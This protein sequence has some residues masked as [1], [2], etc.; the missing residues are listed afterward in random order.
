MV[1]RPLRRDEQLRYIPAPPLLRLRR[2]ELR[3]RVRRMHELIASLT[4]LAPLGQDAVRGALRAE[5]LP[6]VE[7]RGPDRPCDASRNR[8]ECSTARTASRSAT[9]SV[10]AGTVRFASRA[11]APASATR[12]GRRRR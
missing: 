7:Q 4:H 8:S 5:V 6:L 12:D 1:V 3:F 9:E 2:E 10:R 11:A